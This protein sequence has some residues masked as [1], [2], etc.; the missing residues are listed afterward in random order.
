MFESLFNASLEQKCFPNCWKRAN[1]I[2]IFKGKGEQTVVTNYRPVSLT[3]CVSKIF[4]K[5]IYKRLYN[6]LLDINFLYKFQSGFLPGHSTTCQLIELCHSLSLALDNQMETSIVFCDISKAFDRVWHRGLLLKLGRCGV[7]GELYDWF[8]SY[9][10]NRTQRVCVDGQY[11]EWGLTSA[12]VPQGS[13]L[14]PILFLIFINDITTG[15]ATNFR[16]FADD[17]S[18]FHSSRTSATNHVVM[19]NDTDSVANWANEWLITMS[20]PKTVNMIV[21]RRKNQQNLSLVMNNI[22]INLVDDHT[23]LGMTFSRDMTWSYHIERIVASAFKRL[24]I[25]QKLKYKVKRNVLLRLY[26][27]YIRSLLDYGDV[28]YDGCTVNEKMLLESVQIKAGRIISGL[29][30]SCSRENIYSELGWIPLCERRR[31]HKIIMF[32]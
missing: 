23:H 16:I 12:G 27:S 24:G 6:H 19:Q 22:A 4:E 30:R 20:A 1:V 2:P 9:L 21:S 26:I 29:T 31:R 10:H 28:I 25:L 17:A 8:V 11:S 18:Y 7:E 3:S 32:F 13:V 15:T 5:L 14:G